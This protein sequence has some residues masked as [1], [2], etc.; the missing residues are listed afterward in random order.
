MAWAVLD[1]DLSFPV[2]RPVLAVGG[3]SDRSFGGS[4][5]LWDMSDPTAPVP[6]GQPLN[7]PRPVRSVAWAELDGR[8]VLAV[9][10]SDHSFGGSVRLWDMSDPTAPV[11]LGQSLDSSGP[12]RSMAWAELDGRPVLAAGHDGGY[13]S[14]SIWLWEVVED[15][16]AERVP[17]YH[18]D[19]GF[20]GDEL[21]RAGEALAL[22]ELVTA[23]S[24][25]PPLAVGL[26]GDW[27]G[28]KSHFLD[29]VQQQVD[30]TAR[31]NNPLSHHAVRQVRFNAWHYAETGLWASLV[32]ELFTQLAAAPGQDSGTAQRQLS[33][34]SA[35]LVAQRE[36]PRRLRAARQRRDQLQAAL[37]ARESPWSQLTE[38][39][40]RE[41]AVVAG[42]GGEPGALYE[43]MRG[44]G[45]LALGTVR[46]GWRLVRSEPRSVVGGFVL[47]A[48]VVAA[49]SG[50]VVW[51]LPLWARLVS[52]LSALVPVGLFVQK[53]REAR[54]RSRPLRARLRVVME[55]W[56]DRL[57]TAADVAQGEVAVLE[58]EVQDLTAAGQLAGLVSERAANGDYRAHLGLMTQIR[59]DF[60]R[61]AVLL[62]EAGSTAGKR[63]ED[64]AGAED[65]VGGGRPARAPRGGREKRHSR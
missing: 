41:W 34:L 19:A 24:A 40:R 59:E 61:M 56:R 18:S 65:D 38:E 17:P 25:R 30:A 15:R 53:V 13:S 10:D 57:Q 29:L 50:A 54:E 33:R 28:G 64:D 49:V 46:A 60:Q 9:G 48:L 6:L 62:A 4:V 5:R 2:R 58:R 42:D 51:G 7:N 43:Q 55:G 36:L 20:G 47:S 35:D 63:A 14:G 16:L 52:W 27:G 23:R 44:R 3:G 31:P 8:P 12:L 11:P 22:A 37:S 26:F 45:L 32:A 39:Q 21:S 1:G